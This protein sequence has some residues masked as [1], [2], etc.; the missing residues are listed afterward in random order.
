MGLI[1]FNA[2]EGYFVN[3]PDILSADYSSSNLM[4]AN[5]TN[6]CVHGRTITIK[7]NNSSI[8]FVHSA[9]EFYCQSKEPQPM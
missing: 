3:V 2:I 6:S 4:T 8:I 5:S 1:H 9:R 7:C